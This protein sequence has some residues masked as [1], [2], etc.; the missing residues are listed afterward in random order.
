[1]DKERIEELFDEAIDLAC[2]K[3]KLPRKLIDFAWGVNGSIDELNSSSDWKAKLF[4]RGE[5]FFEVVVPI[6]E[7]S[8][9][10][11]I[12]GDMVDRMVHAVKRLQDEERKRA[13]VDPR[14]ARQ[15][16]QMVGERQRRQMVEERKRPDIRRPRKR[17]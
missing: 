14:G 11:K 4:Y 9:D 2:E 10:D 13:G 17:G 16:R 5:R 3:L 6:P 12:K 1:M 8:S 15:G 7:G